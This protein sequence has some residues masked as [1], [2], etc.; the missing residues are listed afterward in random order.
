MILFI[1]FASIFFYLTGSG[2]MWNIQHKRLIAK[3][4]Y[5]EHD[6]ECGHW[7]TEM[8]SALFWPAVV[9]LALG[10][11]LS[12]FDNESRIDRKHERQVEEAKHKQELAR[13]NS[14]TIRIKE[15][16]AGIR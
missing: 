4:T 1:V 13:I 12:G 11:K 10:H 14:E 3:C 7:W 16:E 8:F 15:M 5:R 9:P 2:A 6:F